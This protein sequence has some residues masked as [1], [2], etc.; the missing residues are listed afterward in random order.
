MKIYTKTGD[1]GET[2][3]FGGTRVS[4]ASTRVDAYGQVD[5]LNSVLG[6]VRAADALPASIDATLTRVQSDLFDVG[7]ELCSTPE[8]AAKG[9][10]PLIDEASITRLEQAIDAA[11]KPLQPLQTFVLPGGCEA[12]ARLHMARTTCR[13]A[14]RAVV[15]LASRESVRPL[16]IQYLNRLSDLLFVFARLANHEAGIADVPWVGRS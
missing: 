16:A 3:L 11:E 5:E 6:F 2:G 9:D 10:L 13:R 7:A 8:R 1:Q 12:S 4:K 15:D 14:E